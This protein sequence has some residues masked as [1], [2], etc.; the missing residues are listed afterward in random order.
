MSNCRSTMKRHTLLQPLRRSLTK[1][2]ITRRLP[3][4]RPTMTTDTIFQCLFLRDTLSYP[5]PS[6]TL[7]LLG[8]G[9]WQHRY[10]FP[11]GVSSSLAWGLGGKWVFVSYNTHA[12]HAIHA[13]EPP[14]RLLYLSTCFTLPRPYLNLDTTHIPRKSREELWRDFT[15]FW[16]RRSSLL[17]DFWRLCSRAMRGLYFDCFAGWLATTFYYAWAVACKLYYC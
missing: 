17:G 14:W 6:A 16:R 13:H 4:H 2:M 12:H 9:A 3:N 15:A 11:L 5:N 7:L 1:V 10:F 8:E